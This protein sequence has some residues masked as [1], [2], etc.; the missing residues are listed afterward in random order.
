MQ[1]SGFVQVWLEQVYVA[2]NNM[3]HHCLS[4]RYAA[5]GSCKAT[6]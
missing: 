4:T 3:L 5:G 2:A 1:S 6:I